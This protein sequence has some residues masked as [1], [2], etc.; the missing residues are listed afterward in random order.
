MYSGKDRDLISFHDDKAS[1]GTGLGTHRPDFRR[2]LFTKPEVPYVQK[3]IK[4]QIV[5]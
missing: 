3:G 2:V 5:N 1:L 4:T